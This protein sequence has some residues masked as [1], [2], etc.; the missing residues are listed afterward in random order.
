MAKT[1]LSCGFLVREKMF[2]LCFLFLFC[3]HC[4]AKVPSLYS[5]AG[6][7]GAIAFALAINMLR[8]EGPSEYSELIFTTTLLI[9][10]FT[11]GLQGALTMPL[12]K[13]IGV[14]MAKSVDFSK[15]A[16]VRDSLSRV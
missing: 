11:V 16:R 3:V 6:L 9:V 14:E 12:L 2:S 8:P 13:L 5:G 4:G 7:R 10:L 15:S 1:S